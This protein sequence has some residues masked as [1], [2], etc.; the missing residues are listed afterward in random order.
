[1]KNIIHLKLSK[2]V[3]ECGYLVDN[4]TEIEKEVTCQH[5]LKL[6]E[7]QKPYLITEE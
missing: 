6:M 1:M 4:V 5:C 7:F 3:S 2:N